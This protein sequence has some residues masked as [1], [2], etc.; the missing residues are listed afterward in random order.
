[1][2]TPRF[3]FAGDRDISVWVLEFL[4]RQGVQPLCLLVSEADRATHA[5][6]LLRLCSFLPTQDILVGSDF[7]QAE[8]LARLRLLGLDYIIAVH[9]PY[10]F[11]P[12]ALSLPRIG[13]LNLHPAFLPY[14]RGWHTPSWAILD[15]T[16]IGATLHFMDEGVDTGDIIHQKQ[17]DIL[18]GD[19]AHSLYHRVKRLELTVF[20]EAWTLIRMNNP[21]RNSQTLTEGTIHKRRDLTPVQPIDLDR[22]TTARDVLRHLRGLTTN[23]WDEAAYFE[24]DGERYRVQVIIRQDTVGE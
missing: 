19:T 1:V 8:G 20:E 24:Q 14:N 3:A 23:R 5:D 15:G 6:D 13:V 21:P 4:L 7:R 16:P 2:N 18:P 12:E 9:F 22:S 17:I 10:I 11:P